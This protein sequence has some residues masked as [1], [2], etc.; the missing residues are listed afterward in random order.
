MTSSMKARSPLDWTLFY[1]TVAL[2]ILGAIMV[3]STSSLLAEQR[4]GSHLFF[5]K[6]QLLWLV[7]SAGLMAVVMKADLKRLGQYT[8]LAIVAILI[9]LALVFAMPTRNGSHRWLF[10]GPFALQPSE[11]AKIILLYYL[12]HSFSHADCDIRDYR[13]SLAPHAPLVGLMALL[14]LFEPDLGTVIVLGLTTLSMLYLAGAR[15]L[16][17]AT[18]VAP[19][20]I[21][22]SIMVFGFGHKIGRIKTYLASLSN[23]LEGSYQVKQAI[24]TFGAGGFWGVGL[25]DGRQKH[26]FLPYPHTDFIFAA[27]GEEVGFIGLLAALA[28]Y[29]LVLYR[30]LKIASYQ[31][32]RFGY[33][34]AS[35]I[36]LLLFF[37]IA[38]NIGVVTSLIPTTGL[39]LP[40][41]SYGGSSLLVTLLGI[42]M[43]LNLSRRRD[44]WC[45]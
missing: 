22:G 39:P 20:A 5:I 23:P 32:D 26:F 29:L 11:L 19:M 45:Q 37:N 6:R 2:V 13:K 4:F 44:G 12:A 17:L 33:L 36:T 42:A 1:A 16:H 8:P 7:V 38:I 25:G 41:M 10:L 24:L 21:L 27:A 31:P 34:L 9:A 40:L 28:L 14:I 3:Y 43:L 35:G 15:L 30:G 18:A